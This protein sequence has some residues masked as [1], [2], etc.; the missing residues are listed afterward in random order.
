MFL[1]L[2]ET[3]ERCVPERRDLPALWITAVNHWVSRVAIDT[4]RIERRESAMHFL[5][6]FVGMDLHLVGDLALFLVA[7]GIL[8][9]QPGCVWGEP[10]VFSSRTSAA[11]ELLPIPVGFALA[12]LI[13][14][15]WGIAGL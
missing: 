6:F 7:K 2:I 4:C 9:G 3:F 8:A 11:F 13:V 12:G 14:A 5:A 15:R 1:S 10:Y